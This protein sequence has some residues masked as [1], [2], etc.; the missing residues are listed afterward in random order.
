MYFSRITFNPWVDQQ[1]LAQSLCQDTYRE[2]Q[3]LWKLFDSDPDA[4]RDFLYRQTMEHGR[5]KYYVL[6]ERIPVDHSGIWMIDQAKPYAPK[7]NAGQRLAFTLRANPV[8]TVTSPEGKKQRHDVVMHE[9]KRIDFDRM[10]K[11]ER[12]TVQHLIQSSCI[13]WLQARSEANG[14]E[15]ESEQVIV[16]AYRQHESFSK[17]QKKSVRYSTVDFQG[18]LTVTDAAKF[19]ETL[20]KGIGKSKAFGC[21]LLL[22][23]KFD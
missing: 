20:L 17:Q 16:D 19:N 21:G 1:Q 15:I 5:I 7:L 13:D 3:V 14:F 23:K 8:I 9:K 18:L 12:P 6:S 10:P 2:H 22:V 11:H 4:S